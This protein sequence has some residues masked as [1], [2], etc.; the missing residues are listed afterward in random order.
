MSAWG[1]CVALC[2][3]GCGCGWGGGAP[4]C[5]RNAALL[6]ASLHTHTTTSPPP[7][8]ALSTPKTR[9]RAPLPPPRPVT[10]T[11]PPSPRLTPHPPQFMEL[12]AR[13]LLGLMARDPGDARAAFGLLPES[14]VRDLAAWLK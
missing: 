7:P 13:W 9:P 5:V 1:L 10:P 8:R 4:T 3:C 2:G 14:V 12:T 11:P 6:R